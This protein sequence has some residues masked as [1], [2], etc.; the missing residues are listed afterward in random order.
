MPENVHPRGCPHFTWAELGDPPQALR[1]NGR[2]LARALEDLRSRCGYRT[3]SHNA[4]VG[5]APRSWHL[6]A[7][8]A[9]IPGGYATLEQALASGFTGVGLRDGRVVHVDV[10]PGVVQ[11][12]NDP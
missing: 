3:A 6:R 11:V 5:G 7:L 8:A 10:R 9:D 4:I 2:R 1:P 12:F